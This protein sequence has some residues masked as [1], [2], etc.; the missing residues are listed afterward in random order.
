MM[1]HRIIFRD[2]RDCSRSTVRSRA[3]EDVCKHSRSK[4]S[5]IFGKRCVLSDVLQR[6]DRHVRDDIT[7]QY[8]YKPPQTHHV[9]QVS[10]FEGR[11]DMS[12]VQLARVSD[13][14]TGLSK[15]PCSFDVI[16]ISSSKPIE[17]SR[18]RRRQGDS[19]LCRFCSRLL[20][21]LTPPSRGG[22]MQTFKHFY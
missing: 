7:S 17:L 5:S 22:P 14:R 20:Q 18:H 15:Y 8:N 6:N 11:P 4:L 21:R 13:P 2:A 9:C 19:S 12:P 1:P 10:V 3:V 16:V